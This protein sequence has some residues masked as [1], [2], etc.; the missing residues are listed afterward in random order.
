MEQE[1]EAQGDLWGWEDKQQSGGGGTADSHVFLLQTWPW[2]K[3]CRA[4]KTPSVVLSS[5]GPKLGPCED[6][7]MGCKI[8]CS[9]CRIS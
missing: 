6:S 4:C 2:S 5:S 1:T 9:G 7:S 8:P 3:P